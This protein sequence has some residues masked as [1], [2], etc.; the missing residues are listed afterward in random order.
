[1]RGGDL[2]WETN[3][4]GITQDHVDVLRGSREEIEISRTHIHILR[5][6]FLLI[7]GRVLLARAIDRNCYRLLSLVRDVMVISWVK[8]APKGPV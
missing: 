5:I 7:T 4:S 2:T 6:M 8:V 1:M 3:R